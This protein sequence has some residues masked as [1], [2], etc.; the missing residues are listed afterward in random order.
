MVGIA[1]SVAF[2]LGV[3]VP[4][5]FAV[6]TDQSQS[7]PELESDFNAE[8]MSSRPLEPEVMLGKPD[9]QQSS[10]VWLGYDEY[11]EH[12][13]A[14]SEVEQAAFDDRP[15]GALPTLPAPAAP[16]TIEQP[17]EQPPT[18]VTE[19]KPETENAETELTDAGADEMRLE[20]ETPADQPTLVAELDATD[21]QPTDLPADEI[22]APEEPAGVNAAPRPAGEGPMLDAITQFLEQMIST[23]QKSAEELAASATAGESEEHAAPVEDDAAASAAKPSDES[24]EAES[25]QPAAARPAPRVPASAPA[26][27]PL[28]PGEQTRADEADMESDATSRTE[29]TMEELKLGKPVVARG[30]ELKPRKPVFTNL[31][32]MT[33]LPGNPLCEI[34]FQSNGKPALARLLTTSGDSRVDDALLASL[35]R[36]RASGPELADLGEGETIDVQMRII[37]NVR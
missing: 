15:F 28:R 32:R 22:V 8:D 33:A 12:L 36:W 30:L 29:V 4:G 23:A 27:D 20:R 25:A 21:T 18:E 17:A 24:T 37:F 3:L 7:P 9:R 13:A 10:L 19:A 6:M 34:R 16:E 2:H 11:Q 35:Y 14:L 1:I 5:L 31:I 26:P